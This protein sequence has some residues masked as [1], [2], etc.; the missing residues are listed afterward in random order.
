MMG[1]EGSASLEQMH[2]IMGSNWLGCTN[3][4]A[5][6]MGG[7]MMPMMMRMTGNYYPAYYSGFDTILVMGI[8]GWVLFVITVVYLVSSGAKR[9]K[10]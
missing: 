10:R 5:S 3:A 7:Q 2:I 8:I 9:R 1:G 4:A 6:M